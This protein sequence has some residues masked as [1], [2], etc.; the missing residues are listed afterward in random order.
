[1]WVS[2]TSFLHLP[3][4]FPLF[5]QVFRY[6]PIASGIV[7]FG[8]GRESCYKASQQLCPKDRTLKG[9]GKCSRRP[10]RESTWGINRASQSKKG[11]IKAL[12]TSQW[13]RPWV[14][15]RRKETCTHGQGTWPLLPPQQWGSKTLEKWH[16]GQQRA[17]QKTPSISMK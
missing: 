11:E 8:A 7:Y 3:L 15:E 1:M 14:W 9:L 13:K 10:E 16:K 5:R 6:W 2:I 12:L 17:L 4:F